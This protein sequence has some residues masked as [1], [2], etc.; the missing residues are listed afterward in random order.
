MKIDRSKLKPLY[1]QYSSP[2]NR[3]THA[4]LHTIGSSEWLFSLFLR[5]VV[6]IRELPKKNTYEISTRFGLGS[7]QDK[8]LKSFE[9]YRKSAY[10]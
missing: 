9:R 8:N 4:L 10:K 6:G 2:E 1:D 7:D 3:L 5:N